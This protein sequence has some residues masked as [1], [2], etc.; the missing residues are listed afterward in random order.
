MKQLETVNT[1]AFPL[2]V[3]PEGKRFRI[4]SPRVLAGRVVLQAW[5]DALGAD[6]VII[7]NIP[8]FEESAKQEG[9]GV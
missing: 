1:A 6:P 2:I 9:R 8:D 4:E 7:D 3:R 5:I